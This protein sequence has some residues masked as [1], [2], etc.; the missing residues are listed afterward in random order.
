M[1]V[2]A[3]ILLF[4][5]AVMAAGPGVAGPPTPADFATRVLHWDGTGGVAGYNL[6]PTVALGP[7]AADATPLEPNQSSVFS[8]GWGG[9]ITLGFD[10]PI[11]DDPAHPGGY[12]FIVFGNA[13][14][15]GGDAAFSHREPGYVEVGVD[16]EGRGEY[17]D[18]SQVRW[19]WL[20]G[21]PG[22]ATI[23][24]FP[25]AL[26]DHD[27]PVYGYAD[28]TPTDGSGNPLLPDD[29]HTPGISPG[30]AGGDA[31]DLAWAVDA[32][33][34]PVTITRADF[35]RI[36]C[37][38]DL[39]RPPV[40]RLSTEVDAVALMRPRSFGDLDG[41]GAVTLA[42]AVLVARALAGGITL[43]PEQAAEADADA[44]GEI[45][46]SDARAILARAAGLGA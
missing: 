17:G 6:D 29:P 39:V 7:P 1:R 16:P 43:T 10:R 19:Y 26:P 35:I 46:A 24:G 30:S 44:D 32:D 31:F 27:T 14:Y 2:F 21:S 23:A 40:G 33:G 20:R 18:G 11:L 9:S 36:T 41:D 4:A 12:D 5:L 37:A 8:F 15:Q 34:R 13:L 42:D 45:T 38:V 22:P 28:L 25:M 3:G